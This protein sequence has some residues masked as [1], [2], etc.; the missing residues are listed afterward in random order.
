MLWYKEAVERV[1]KR[2]VKYVAL[3]GCLGGVVW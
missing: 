3:I 1:V 2:A